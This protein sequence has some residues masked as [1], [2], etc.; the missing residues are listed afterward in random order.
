MSILPWIENDYPVILRGDEGSGKSTLIAAALSFIKNKENS[1]LTLIQGSSLYGAQDL[2]ARI[3]RACI[4]F[5]SSSNGRTYKP[6]NGSR[7]ILT[8]KD[9]HLAS[10]EMQVS[11]VFPYSTKIKILYRERTNPSIFCFCFYL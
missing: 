1:P 8:L 4:R 10:K 7:F 11:I 5:D 6:R 9:V 3:K 2:I